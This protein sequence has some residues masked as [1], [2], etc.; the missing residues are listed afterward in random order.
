MPEDLKALIRDL[1]EGIGALR[2]EVVALRSE[3]ARQADAQ[4]KQ[5]RDSRRARIRTAIL[6]LI[7]VAIAAY[8]YLWIH[9]A[10]ARRQQIYSGFCFLI[11]TTPD[12][13]A[14]PFIHTFREH[15]GC[16]PYDPAKAKRE[17]TP[18]PTTT[19][20]AHATATT[21]AVRTRV[22]PTPVPTVIPGAVRTVTALVPEPGTRVTVTRTRTVT[23]T[24]S[25]PSCLSI[26]LPPCV[27]QVA[28]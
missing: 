18:T 8:G 12:N 4:V 5:E 17:L 2:G 19:V 6:A 11:S 13:P 10:S 23:R 26:H 15:F 1:D 22:M 21:T 28:N 24:V 25:P 16:P 9:D 3:A 27:L 7:V 14:Q 20:T